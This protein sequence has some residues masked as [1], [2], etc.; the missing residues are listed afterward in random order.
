ME[1]QAKRTRRRSHRRQAARKSPVRRWDPDRR[2]V[3]WIDTPQGDDRDAISRADRTIAA[4]LHY[5]PDYERAKAN[6]AKV[7][8]FVQALAGRRLSI[9]EIIDYEIP[10]DSPDSIG[11]F[12]F[13]LTADRVRVHSTTDKFKYTTIEPDEWRIVA[14][15]FAEAGDLIFQAAESHYQVQPSAVRI[16]NLGDNKSRATLSIPTSKFVLAEL[17]ARHVRRVDGERRGLGP[18]H[19]LAAIRVIFEANADKYPRSEFHVSTHC[20]PSRIRSSAGWDFMQNGDVEIED[21]AVDSVVAFIRRNGPGTATQIIRNGYVVDVPT[22][23]GE[24]F[25]VEFGA[26]LARGLEE[27]RRPMQIIDD[28]TDYQARDRHRPSATDQ[29]LA[30][31]D[32][33]R[34]PVPY[35]LEPGTVGLDVTGLGVTAP[36]VDAHR[37]PRAIA[38]TP[39][40]AIA[41]G[42][43]ALGGLAQAN[44]DAWADALVALV[45]NGIRFRPQRRTAPGPLVNLRDVLAVGC[46]ALDNL[47]GS[48]ALLSHSMADAIASYTRVFGGPK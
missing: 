46:D 29:A 10:I 14:T 45:R 9:D 7:R 23:I 41:T 26:R 13:V 34:P 24:K 17:Y 19:D 18:A 37:F 11:G 32:A 40:R 22:V 16:R 20:S 15:S 33:G 27:V 25:S 2:P 39:G 12:D 21:D 6:R 3:V 4:P 43:D 47:A 48:F 38:P 35:R 31:I 5:L 1:R 28:P 30:A 42:S 36:W 8:A 44:R